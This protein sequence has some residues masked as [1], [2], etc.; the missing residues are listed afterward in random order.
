[1]NQGAAKIA[2][3]EAINQASNP[4]RPP[5]RKKNPAI[6]FNSRRLY[7]EK[8]ADFFFKL[9]ARTVLC[10]AVINEKTKVSI[11]SQ[12]RPGLLQDPR[13]QDFFILE[14]AAGH[15]AKLEREIFLESG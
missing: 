8:P 12:K 15:G 13:Y 4:G 5:W 7:G 10:V 1:M 3:P 6:F 14:R 2:T 9:S 11:S